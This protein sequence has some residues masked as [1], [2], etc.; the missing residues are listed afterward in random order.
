VLAVTRR[1]TG[2]SELARALRAAGLEERLAIVHA[3]PH[4]FR[5]GDG[6]W[7]SAAGIEPEDASRLLRAA[8]GKARLPEPLRIAHLVARALVLGQSRG[9]V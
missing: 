8:T 3:A 4:A 2:R 5:A 9:R 7:V 1:S 6:L